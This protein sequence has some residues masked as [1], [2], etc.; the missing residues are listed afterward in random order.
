VILLLGC[1]VSDAEW[2]AA[3]DRDQ[4][5]HISDALD[6]GTD[7]DDGN[8][9]VNPDAEEVCDGLDNDCDGGTDEFDA[10]D[11]TTW[12]ADGDSDGAGD[13]AQSIAACQA[14]T[15]YVDN[16]GD[17]DDSTS[18]VGPEVDEICRNGVDDDCDGST[19]EGCDTG[20][21]DT[22]F[23]DTGKGDTG[24]GD[25]GKGDTGSVLPC[26]G[27]TPT[28]SDDFESGTPGTS[29]IGT[30]G[31]SCPFGSCSATYSTEQ[32]YTGTQSLDLGGTGGDVGRADAFAADACIAFS[33]WDPGG[34]GAF[35]ARLCE[36]CD[37]DHHFAGFPAECG[38][39]YC[40]ASRPSTK[41]ATT[42]VLL[43]ER[44]KGWHELRWLVDYDGK[45]S[46]EYTVCVDGACTESIAFAETFALLQF[47][48]DVGGTYIDDYQVLTP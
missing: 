41:D 22:G 7:C 4:D 20:P 23:Q 26:E 37:D 6:G 34:K 44:T 38:D 32:A 36:T 5:G 40:A 8:A 33:F 3:V 31:W 11:A 10:I 19:D 21:H 27:W 9:T 14:P 43:G 13:A 42:T 2:L 46:G 35:M 24:K 45:A 48:D 17:C 15:G 16:A 39:S 18:A 1:F 25:T 47:V 29:P 28:T 12:Y 30:D